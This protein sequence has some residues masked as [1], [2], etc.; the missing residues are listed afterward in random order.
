MHIDFVIAKTKVKERE[1]YMLH[2]LC[3]LINSFI[4]LLVFFQVNLINDIFAK[5]S[6][7]LRAFVSLSFAAETNQLAFIRKRANEA[8]TCIR[9]LLRIIFI[10]VQEKTDTS[11]NVKV[12]QQ[13][14]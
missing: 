5:V 14:E 7:E 8:V 10:R 12:F 1:R 4:I 2:A 3:C 11:H 9:D 6:F 13:Y